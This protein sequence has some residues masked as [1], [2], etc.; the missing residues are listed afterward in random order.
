MASVSYGLIYALVA[1]NLIVAHMAKQPVPVSY[2]AYAL[3][4]LGAAN[5]QLQVADSWTLTGVLMLIA[6]LGYSHYVVNII[7]EICTHLGLR[8][9]LIHPQKE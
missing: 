5:S 9:F 8:V 6:L 1:S 4:F 2:W 3:L 7:N